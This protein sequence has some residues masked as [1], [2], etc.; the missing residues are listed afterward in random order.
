MEKTEVIRVRMSH[1][2]KLSV[3]MNAK[4]MNCSISEYTRLCLFQ[5]NHTDLKMQ[6][7]IA[8]GLCRLAEF[9]K[10]IGNPNVR[11]QAVKEM[12]AIWQSIR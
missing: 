1:A 11:E 3:E 9:I 8:R 2:E 12:D 10:D 6:Q 4:E 5:P 7:N